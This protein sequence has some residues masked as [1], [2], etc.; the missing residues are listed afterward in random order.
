MSVFTCIC[1]QLKF[2]EYLGTKIS[3]CKLNNFKFVIRR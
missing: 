2:K 3:K 1:D